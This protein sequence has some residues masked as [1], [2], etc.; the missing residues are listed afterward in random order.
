MCIRDRSL[1]AYALKGEGE[2]L[3]LTQ[4]YSASLDVLYRAEKMALS[5]DDLVLNEGIYNLLA[6]NN[7]VLNNFEKFQYYNGKY[8]EVQKTLEQNELKSLNRYLNTQNLE[9]Q[10]ATTATNTQFLLYRMFTVLLVI[11]MIAIISKKLFSL[12]K[13]N[14]R[15]RKLIETLTK[16]KKII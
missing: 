9:E 10:K 15:Q 6:N 16:A 5:S 7:L 13:R 11:A 8:L 12:K 3:F 14:R 4:Q 1:E 2:S